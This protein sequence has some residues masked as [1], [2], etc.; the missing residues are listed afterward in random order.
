MHELSA[1]YALDALTPEEERAFEQHLA[2]CPRCQDDV[3]AFSETAAL[4]AYGSPP[5]HRSAALRGRILS[6]ATGERTRV[7]AR[8]RGWRYPAAAAFASCAAIGLGV[9]AVTLHSQLSRSEALQTLSLH[10]ARGSVVV[11]RAGGAALVISG[12]KTAPAGRTYEMWVLR[13]NRAQPAGLFAARPG[14]TTVRVGRPLAH[15]ERVAV[16]LEP[17]AGSPQPTGPPLFT[18]SVD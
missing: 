8:R 15:G 7:S 2:R 14:T 17:A 9:W 18:S 11:G 10:G 16:T 13:G 12:L 1:G 3:A 5:A 4:L 6:A